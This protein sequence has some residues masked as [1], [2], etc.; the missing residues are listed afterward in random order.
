MDIA[1]QLIELLLDTTTSIAERDDAAIDLS[2]YSTPKVVEALLKVAQDPNEDD[3][4]ASS[5]GESLGQIW[6]QGSELNM[7]LLYSLSNHA[8][9][10]TLAVLRTNRPEWVERYG[11]DKIGF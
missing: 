2:D 6:S 11:L 7:A 10:E 8:K 1:D 3:L 9:H 4:V 5:A